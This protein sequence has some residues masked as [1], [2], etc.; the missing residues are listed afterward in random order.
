[1]SLATKLALPC[2]IVAS[3]A[4][5]HLSTVRLLQADCLPDPSDVFSFLKDHGIG[6]EL[7]LFYIAHA[8]YLEQQGNYSAADH[9]YQQGINRLAAPLDRLQAKYKDFEHRMARRIQRKA[10]QQQAAGEEP[11]HPERQSLSVLGGRGSRR[12][13]GLPSQ[14]RK[15]V[16]TPGKANAPAGGGLAIFVD[17]EFGGPAASAPAA[18]HGAG[19]SSSASIG[20]GGAGPAWSALPSFEQARKE[21]MQKAASWAGQKIKQ[22]PVVSAPPAPT[23][24]IPLDPEFE[25]QEQEA[26]R[27][28]AL[29]AAQ[30]G[31]LR[32]RLERGGIEEQLAH[33]P[34]RLHRGEPAQVP[35]QAPEAAKPAPAPREQVFGCDTAG[36]QDA[37]GEDV[38]FEEVRAIRWLENNHLP[39]TRVIEPQGFQAV[40]AP[41]VA[42]LKVQ[43]KAPGPTP[44]DQPAADSLAAV[45]AGDVTMNTRSAFE[46][47]NAVFGGGFGAFSS[48]EDAAALDPTMTIATKDAFAAINSMFKV[49]AC[50]IL[51]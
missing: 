15:A 4:R 25:A 18:L 45:A 8:T 17:E 36:L 14:K 47:V 48:G 13:G 42:A 51:T 50:G 26:V 27:R 34:L 44:F 43:Q 32:Q 20:A 29:A 31:T 9:T 35:A 22:K 41:N 46:A 11:A 7:S 12:T 40:D 21:N 1:M 16:A 2:N 10:Q 37:A 39:V 23:L 5:F 6:Q 49:G 38:S 30:Q 24:D 3:S 28:A 33:D 19:T